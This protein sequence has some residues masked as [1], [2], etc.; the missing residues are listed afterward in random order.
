VASDNCRDPFYAY[1]DLDMVEVF[2][3]ATRIA[4]FDCQPGPAAFGTWP[5]AATRGPAAA[6]GLG[7]AGTVTMGAP[8]DLVLFRARSFTELL[9]RPQMD[10]IVLRAGAAIETTPPDYRTLDHLF[11]PAIS[12]RA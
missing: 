6:M 10:R 7:A 12:P 3:E 8:A 4:H 1:G 9:S 2:R 11:D 5:A